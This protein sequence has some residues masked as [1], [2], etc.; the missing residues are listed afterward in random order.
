MSAWA[1][2]NTMEAFRKVLETSAAGVELD[3]HLSAD[4]MPVICHDETIDRTSDGH[5]LLADMTYRQLLQ[6]DFSQVEGKVFP[7]AGVCRIPL[8]PEV[9]ELFEPTGLR[10]NIEL[11]TDKNPYP[12]IEAVVAAVIREAKM[13]QRVVVSSFNASSLSRFSAVA[14]K[15]TTGFLFVRPPR[16]LKRGIEERRWDAVH[17]R[18]VYAGGALVRDAHARG[19]AVRAYTVDD[20]KR[21]VRLAAKGV[22]A[23]FSNNPVAI[24]DALAQAGE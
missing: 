14:P 8:L 22:D 5:G 20:P 17:P 21:A 7:E 13:E 10:V 9:L 23:V 24:V 18:Y 3:V 4:G 6:Y 12:G 16:G 2:E 15:I 19:M 1:P 11:K